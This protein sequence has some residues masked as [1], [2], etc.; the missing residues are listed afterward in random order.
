M[1]TLIYNFTST[2]N[3][4]YAYGSI[5]QSQD[6]PILDSKLS[7]GSYESDSV[8]QVELKLTYDNSKSTCQT[9]SLSFLAAKY[10]L[11]GRLISFSALDLAELDVCNL[12]ESG[13][14]RI[15]DISFIAVNYK[16]ACKIRVDKLMQIA[17]IEPIFYE[18]YLRYQ[19]ENGTFY[20]LPVQIA[21]NNK[22]TLGK[23]F[24][25]TDQYSTKESQSGKNKYKLTISTTN[26]YLLIYR[27]CTI[28]SLR[29]INRFSFQAF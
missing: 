26:S 8:N 13:K 9:S 19:F 22:N 25:I 15:S 21:V 11:N 4:C 6:L 24:F 3:V 27:T 10:R 5:P 18:L 2:I 16:K 23:R 29:I 12:F 14:T 7:I 17:S 1:C 28:H 20:L